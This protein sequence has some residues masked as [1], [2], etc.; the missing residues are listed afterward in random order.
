MVFICTALHKEA[1]PFIKFYNLKK[2]L[3]SN[4]FQIFKNDTITLIISGSGK[5]KA[6][7]AITYL[8]C[9]YKFSSSDILINIGICGA[10]NNKDTNIGDIFLINK[11]FDFD[12][13]RTYYPDLILNNNFKESSIETHS[14]VVTSSE[15]IENNLVDME[16]SSIYVS[17]STFLN[18]HQ[19]IFIKIISDFLNN[20]QNLNINIENL[21]NKNKKWKNLYIFETICKNFTY[22][23]VKDEGLS[24]KKN[25]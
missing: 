16:S 24:F 9:N 5:I 13:K 10:K 23:C 22:Y 2:D 15:N 20:I 14:R 12:E 3:N 7:V 19:I 17:S 25:K 11:I 1:N 6:S 18:Q 21:I 8:I 4:K